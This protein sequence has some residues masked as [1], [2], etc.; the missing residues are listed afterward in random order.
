M[1]S[2]AER[3]RL[4]RLMEAWRVLLALRDGFRESLRARETAAL[5][6]AL[7]IVDAAIA[8]EEGM[9]ATRDKW[10]AVAAD[11]DRALLA[12]L[13]EIAAIRDIFAAERPK[14]KEEAAE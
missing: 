5:G 3:A 9:F 7:A 2:D 8:I 13:R 10:G 11:P 4:E 6:T 12:R 1:P 14:E